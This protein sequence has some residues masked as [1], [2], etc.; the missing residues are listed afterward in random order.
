MAKILGCKFWGQDSSIC[1]INTKKKEIFA[2]NADRSSRIKK[3][4]FDIKVALIE[5]KEKLKDVDIVTSPFNTFDG[6]DTCLENKGSSYF[7]L[8]FNEDIRSI[9][10]PK[11]LDDFKNLKLFKIKFKIFFKSNI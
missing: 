6:Y 4:N 10:K 1:L 9:L 7:W 5:N 8:N 3:D 2:L 11:Y